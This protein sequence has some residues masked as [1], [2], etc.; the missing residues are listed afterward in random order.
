MQLA[1]FFAL[2]LLIMAG[3]TSVS[4]QMPTEQG[5]ASL[6]DSW[7]LGVGREWDYKTTPAYLPREVTNR[8]DV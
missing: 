6:P 7:L 2:C 1:T 3:T 4:A 5:H 8:E